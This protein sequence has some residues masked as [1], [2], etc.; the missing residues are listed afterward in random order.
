MGT[1]AVQLAKWMGARVTAVTHADN[2]VLLRS[3][4]ADMVLDYAQADVTRGDDRYDVIID[5]SGLDGIGALLRTLKPGGTLVCVG[6]RGGF[7]RILAAGLRR[8]LLRQRVRGLIAKPNWEDMAKMGSLVAEGK[9]KPIIERVYSLP[10]APEAMA[11]AELHRAR[12]KL[13]IRVS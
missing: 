1:F 4:G 3:A 6:G 2:A 11:R 9:V 7:R 13:V 8:R 10:E 5:V 12:G